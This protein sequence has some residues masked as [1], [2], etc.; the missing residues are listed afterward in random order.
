VRTAW[1]A[2]TVAWA[3][4]ALVACNDLHDFSGHWHGPR[5]GTDPVL[6]V[7]VAEAA[8]ADVT[9]TTINAHGIAGSLAIDGLT[10]DVAF[11]SIAG[12]E[13]DAVAGL[14]FSGSPLRVYLAFVAMPDGGGDALAMVALYDDHRLE[15]RVM[16]GGAAPLYAIFALSEG[17]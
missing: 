12:A 3:S 11:A 9:I 15:L 4:L 13:A 8:T 16:R 10:T 2:L 7:G 1:L 6:A 17:A 5:V 14:T